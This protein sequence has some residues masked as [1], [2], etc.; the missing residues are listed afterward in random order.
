MLTDAG[1]AR[2]W[3]AKQQWY[4]EN[5]VLPVEEGGERH[6]ASDVTQDDGKGCIDS[7]PTN[8]KWRGC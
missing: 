1:Y 5:G 6:A 7:Q 2:R 8:K 3:A 4:R